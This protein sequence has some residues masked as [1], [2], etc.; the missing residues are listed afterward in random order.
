PFTVYSGSVSS[1]CA[2]ADQHL[3]PRWDPRCGDAPVKYEQRSNPV[4][5]TFVHD[6]ESA[7][8]LFVK[9]FYPDPSNDCKPRPIAILSEAATTF[10]R[11][12]V[13]PVQLQGKDG[14]NTSTGPSNVRDCIDNFV[15]PREIASLRNAARSATGNTTSGS[16]TSVIAPGQLPL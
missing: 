10:G 12:V 15:Y 16:S 1:L 7:V 3:L 11:A 14:T 6:T 4:F 2:M 8:E 13:G 5:K 9:K